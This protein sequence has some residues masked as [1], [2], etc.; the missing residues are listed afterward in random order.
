MLDELASVAKRVELVIRTRPLLPD[1]DDEMVLET[2]I[3]GHAH[4]IV[5]FSERHF[6][7]VAARFRCRVIRPGQ[8]VRELAEE[9]EQSQNKERY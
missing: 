3:N 2:A 9:R 1:P 5:T 4:A 6:P 7:P 8:A